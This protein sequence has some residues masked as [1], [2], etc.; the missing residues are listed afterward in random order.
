MNHL[1]IR[2]ILLFLILVIFTSSIS[3]AQAQQESSVTLI[4]QLVI[5]SG[6]P[7]PGSQLPPQQIVVLQ[8]MSGQT[9]ARLTAD[10]YTVSRLRGQRVLITGR[11]S[12][13][14]D[15]QSGGATDLPLIHVTAIEPT[16][17][18]QSK[19][20]SEVTISGSHP[21][22]NILCRFSDVAATP[23]SPIQY[24][25][26]FRSTYPG[27]DHYWR[28]ISFNQADISGTTVVS[29]WYTLPFPRSAYI[30][31]TGTADLDKLFADCAG[32]ADADVDYTQFAGI[33]LMFN[34]WLDC[35][36]WGGWRTTTLDGQTKTWSVTWIPP[37]GQKYSNIAHEMGHGFGLLH[38]S[39]P[40]VNPPMGSAIYVSQWD[41]MSESR[42][43]CQFDDKDNKAF[44]CLPP[45][46]IAYQQEMMGWIPQSRVALVESGQIAELTLENIRQ[47]VS[48]A[49]YLMA[50][51][52]INGS[53]EH[54]YTVE[55]RFKLP[56]RENYDQSVPSTAIVIHDVVIG[57]GGWPGTNTGPAL[58]VV[59]NPEADIPFKT[60]NGQGAIWKEGETFSDTVND[61]RIHIIGRDSNTFTIRIVN[62][63]IEAPGLLTPENNT[64]TTSLPSFAWNTINNAASYEIQIDTR[65]D[66]LSGG[67]IS[68]QTTAAAYTLPGMLASG[69]D[70]YWRVRALSG[71]GTVS[72]WSTVSRFTLESNNTAMPM[73]AQYTTST[74]TLT[75]GPLTWA[76]GYKIEVS[77]TNTFASL[78]FF[79]TVEGGNT[80][81]VQT[82]PL[83]HG[84]YYWRVCPSRS[85][86]SYSA[87]SAVDSFVIAAQ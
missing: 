66:F 28:Q 56:G 33:N 11:Q 34:D 53:A 37:W 82:E 70:Y 77:Q 30:P 6:D 4:G 42:G 71:S 59:E 52:P 65:S 26:L 21:W 79:K 31:Q 45:G 50:K 14:A 76:T 25:A 54:F 12:D 43:T 24:Q 67:V 47:P 40:S 62:Q 64:A 69:M 60:V 61:I 29:Q 83:S 75:W 9:I 35:C 10:P 86:N 80:A 38:S 2:L 16:G 46:T 72:G 1:P 7:P 44:G 81:S 73:R 85:D 32:A 39:G 74:P 15:L 20:S 13:T 51:I 36:S 17:G 63:A 22:I 41:V 3:S 27:L 19:P 55:A 84:I 49:S 5:L 23:Y 78:S 48:T 87:C 18:A 58:V 68:T 57:R 8:D